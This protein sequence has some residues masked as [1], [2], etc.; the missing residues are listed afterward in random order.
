MK[1]SGKT[2]II[3]G[4]WKMNKAPAEAAALFSEISSG[5][6]A[7]CCRVILCVPFVDLLTVANLAADTEICV[8]AQN[9]HFDNEG[10][11]TG[12]ISPAMLNNIGVNH[13]ILGHSERRKYFGETDETTNKKVKLAIA[14]GLTPIVCVGETLLERDLGVT[15]EKISIQI[16][17]LLNGVLAPQLENLIIAYE[18]VWAVGSGRCID[19]ADLVH[20]C[21]VI[22]A[23][24][25]SL[26][27][28]KVANN[29]PILYG[30]S[31]NS[32]NFTDLLNIDDID[33][34]LVGG[35]SLVAEEF[36]KIVNCT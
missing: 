26:Y 32:Q 15:D 29:V 30:G 17:K 7:D 33:G 4:N 13:V 31:I 2:R 5:L 21:K 11:Y 23:S 35:A 6:T 3:V 28:I 10:A 34:G 8:G 24:L 1:K 12:E 9:C 20:V 36:L 18:P 22:R 19:H 14:S 27:G 16:K 25:S